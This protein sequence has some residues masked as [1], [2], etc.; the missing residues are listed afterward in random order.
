M[1]LAKACT[2][3]PSKP[4]RLCRTPASQKLFDLKN[5]IDNNFLLG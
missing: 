5:I 1:C 4:F 2:A 3:L